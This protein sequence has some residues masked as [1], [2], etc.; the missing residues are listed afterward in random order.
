MKKNSVKNKKMFYSFK[1]FKEEF[2]PKSSKEESEMETNDPIEFGAKLA[3]D[4]M[5]EIRQQMAKG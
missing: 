1:E 2:F 5:K 3:N 4:F